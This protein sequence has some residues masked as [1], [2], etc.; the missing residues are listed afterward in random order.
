MFMKEMGVE[1][2]GEMSGHI[3][4]ADRY[5][6]FDDAIYVSCRFVEIVSQTHNPCKYL[7]SGSAKTL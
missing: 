4:L 5:L 2:A 7:F 1:F 6:G 3:F